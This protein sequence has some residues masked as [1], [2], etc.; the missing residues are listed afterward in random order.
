MIFQLRH[1]LAAATALHLNLAKT[2]IIPLWG[3]GCG[4]LRRN[5]IDI[6]PDALRCI[7]EDAGM[8][9]GVI[10]GPGA[11]PRRWAAMAERLCSRGQLVRLLGGV[12]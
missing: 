6:V 9:L 1:M 5:L 2:V 3:D 7:I 8:Y 10:I 11:P 12:F 4:G